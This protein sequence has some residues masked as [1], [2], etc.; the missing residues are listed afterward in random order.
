MLNLPDNFAPL[1]AYRQFIVCQFVPDPEQ[2]GKTFKYPL[3][4]YTLARSDAHNANVWL[5][6][7]T[8]LQLANA[9]GFGYGIGFVFTEND[10]FFF[11]DIDHCLENGA[12]SPIA[13]YLMTEFTGS[14]IEVSQSGTGLHLIGYGSAPKHRR[15]K[16][17]GG[18]FELYTEGRFVALTGTNAAGGMLYDHTATLH[19]LVE[20]Y[21]KKSEHE[22]DG[23]AWTTEPRADWRGPD[24]DH[25]LIERAKR[26]RS[27]S[28]AFSDKASFADLWDA[29]HDALGKAF[30]HPSKPFDASNADAALAQ[31]LAFWTG[32]NCERIDRIMRMSALARDK[33]S[34]DDYMEMTITGAVSRQRDVLTDRAVEPVFSVSATPVHVAD[35]TPVAKPV[36][37]NTF[38]GMTEQIELFKGCVYVADLHRVFTPEGKLVK[39]E[40]FKVLYGGY[41]FVMDTRNERTSRNAFEAFTESQL[42]RSPRCDTACFRPDWPSGAIVNEGGMSQLNTY[43]PVD[44]PR[45]V[46]DAMPFIRHLEKILP[47]ETD[48]LIF[49]SYIAAVV[50]FPGI[51]FQYCPLLQGV[52]GNGKSL[53]THCVAYAIGEKYTHFPRAD[54]VAKN[55]NAWL[56][57]SIFIG[58]EDIKIPETDS[59]ILEILKPMITSTKQA[60]E[61]KGVDSVTKRI[62]CNLLMNANSKKAVKKSHNDRRLCIFYTPQQTK[63]DLVRDGMTR[64]YFSDL[65][66]WLNAGGFAI[67]A[68]LLHTYPIPP[69]YNPASGMIAPLTSSHEEVIQAGASRVEQEILEAIEQGLP[70]FAGGW[71]SSIAL[72][73]LLDN[74][75]LGRTVPRNE[76]R[77][78]L[79]NIG[80]DY[81]PGLPDGRVNNIIAPDNGKPRLYVSDSHG[82]KMISGGVAAIARAY[83]DAQNLAAAVHV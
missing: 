24:D 31:H 78:L 74:A 17:Q 73:R 80:Y 27:A 19:R 61:P 41:S 66:D 39:P 30:P 53:F 38:A 16:E 18:L 15:K 70:G 22:T 1:R 44:V 32:C 36:T 33:W 7:D 76:R 23:A 49:M 46:G 55:F 63:A 58:I 40:V 52:E 71:I 25:A 43:V 48:R 54:Q 50:Q 81:H 5:D 82:A 9:R 69:E 62:C 29:D 42:Y 10:P 26:S 28:S 72:D 60:I 37:G 14:A 56:Y 12:W 47:V 2:P 64:K 3:D 20:N 79:N 35:H 34:R 21:L 57:G 77:T 67:V 83:T 75:N 51:K 4:P 59:D 45:K 68:E 65:Y 11:I 6:A 13:K 8:A